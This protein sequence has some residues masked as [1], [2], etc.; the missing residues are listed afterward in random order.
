MYLVLS[1]IQAREVLL[2]QSEA[3]FQLYSVTCKCSTKTATLS[4]C[5]MK[6]AHMCSLDRANI[7][8]HI[9]TGITPA[10]G[11]QLEGQYALNNGQWQ[12]VAAPQDALSN[13]KATVKIHDRMRLF[14]HP[15]NS[16]ITKSLAFSMY[17]FSTVPYYASYHGFTIQDVTRLQ[18][19]A[20]KLIL[21]RPWIQRIHLPHVFRFLK[22]APLCDPAIALIRA[23]IGLHL[24]M[25]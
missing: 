12:Q 24:R 7:G 3:L 4:N 20:Q 19:M 1:P 25:G 5:P 14:N 11:L 10:L 17:I 22:I 9:H 8:A 13:V 2:G 23:M 16:V 21:G 18:S 15:A 6:A